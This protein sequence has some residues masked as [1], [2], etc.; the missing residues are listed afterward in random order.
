MGLLFHLPMSLAQKHRLQWLRSN[1]HSVIC[2]TVFVS[3]LP[4]SLNRTNVR[5]SA[6]D[7][8]LWNRKEY[9]RGLLREL[10]NNHLLVNS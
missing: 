9:F 3:G 10:K 2:L 7:S 8:Q 5:P 4:G 1:G 6:R